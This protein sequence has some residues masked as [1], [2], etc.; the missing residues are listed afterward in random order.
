MNKQIILAL[1]MLSFSFGMLGCGAAPKLEEKL[2][3]ITAN[4]CS[5]LRGRYTTGVDDLD[6]ASTGTGQGCEVQMLPRCNDTYT[7]RNYDAATGTL[8]LTGTSTVISGAPPE[9]FCPAVDN[10]TCHISILG[11]TATIDCGNGPYTYGVA[12]R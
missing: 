3:S 10:P 12:I 2:A 7:L 4:N 11:Q 6:I 9:P 8:E 5:D 1:T